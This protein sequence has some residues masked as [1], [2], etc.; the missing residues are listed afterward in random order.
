VIARIVTWASTLAALVLV[1]S[2]GLF[3]LDQARSGSKQ[4][5]NKIASELGTSPSSSNSAA[6]NVNQADPSPRTERARE[7]AHGQVREYIDDADDWLVSPFAGVVDSNSIWV[8]RGV[9]SLI[10]FL[11][12]AVGLRI[13]AAYL[14]GGGRR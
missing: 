4:Q 8:Q 6:G 14:P 3:A 11:L 5:V 10:A 2:F 12:F 13:L 7:K 9:P 1:I